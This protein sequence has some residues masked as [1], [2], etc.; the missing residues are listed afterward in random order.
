M[1]LHRA[2]VG[3]IAGALKLRSGSWSTNIALVILPLGMIILRTAHLHVQMINLE[4]H[5]RQIEASQQAVWKLSANQ[6]M[7][8]RLTSEQTESYLFCMH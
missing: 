1:L 5:S 7:S 6:H 4:L 3:A 8:S 2:N